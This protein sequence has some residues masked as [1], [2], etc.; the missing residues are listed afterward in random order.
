MFQYLDTLATLCYA[1][2]K[3]SAVAAAVSRE[4]SFAEKLCSVPELMAFGP[5]FRSSEPVELTESETEYVVC[6]V[7]HSFP[8]HLVLQV[9]TLVGFK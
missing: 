1:G 4:E 8:Q 9:Q 7:K 6:C 3:V 2:S 5:L